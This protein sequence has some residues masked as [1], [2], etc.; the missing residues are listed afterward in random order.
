MRR[1]LA[2]GS[3]VLLVSFAQL[4]MKWGMT[5]LPDPRQWLQLWQDIGLYTAPLSAVAA[6]IIAYAVS[7]GCWMVA[8]HSLPL[9]RAYPMLSLSYGLVYLL[10]GTLPGFDEEYSIIRSLGVALIAGGVILINWRMR[11]ATSN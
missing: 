2:A 7:M 11:A 3:S 1:Y 6:G 5:Q 9:S 8:L 4:A 10:A